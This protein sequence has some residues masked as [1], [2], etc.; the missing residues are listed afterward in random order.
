[1]AS[2]SGR[3]APPVSPPPPQS[4]PPRQPPPTSSSPICSSSLR[5][6]NFLLAAARSEDAM[7]CAPLLG[8][9]RTVSTMCNVHL[10][11]AAASKD[12]AMSCA[13]LLGHLWQVATMC[14]K[15]ISCKRR[16]PATSQCRVLS[17]CS[18]IPAVRTRRAPLVRPNCMM[19]RGC[20]LLY[21]LIDVLLPFGGINP[22]F[23]SRFDSNVEGRPLMS[24]TYFGVTCI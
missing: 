3:P 13:P 15:A 21:V 22:S 10:L 12:A 9:L 11:S 14:K 6:V 24:Y 8:H 18:G 4:P 5:N 2:A 17:A 16:H 7:S 19:T 20:L 1:V 23:S